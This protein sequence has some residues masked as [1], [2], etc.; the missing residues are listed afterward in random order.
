MEPAMR[1]RIMANACRVFG[2]EM[3][4]LAGPSRLANVA[5]ARQAVYYVLRHNRR[6]SYLQ[7]AMQMNRDHSTVIHG[8]RSITAKMKADRSLRLQVIRCGQ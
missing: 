1:P 6:L 3:D 2:V 5:L 8:V 7:I 4:Q